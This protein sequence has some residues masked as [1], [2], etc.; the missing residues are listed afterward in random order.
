M[1]IAFVLP[2]LIIYAALFIFPSV[3]AFYISLFDWNGF[4]SNMKFVG[5]GNFKELLGDSSFWGIAVWNSIRITFLGGFMIFFLAFLLSGILTLPRL[6]GK[7]IFRAMIFFPTIVNPIAIAI[8]WNFIYNQ[9]SG[10]LNNFFALV[11][12]E[13]LQRMWMAPDRL[14]YSILVAL[15]WMNT[16]FYCVILLAALDRVPEGHIEAA[17]LEGASEFS[18]FFRIKLPL[19][20]NVL[21]TALTLWAINSIKEF[22]LLYSWGGGIDIPQPGATN[23][24]VK[25]YV[26]A[27][28]KRVTVYRMGYAT[29]MGIIMFLM[30]GIFVVTITCISRKQDQLEY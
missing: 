12:L 22:A 9:K 3:Q 15:V 25:M 20:S 23:M 2:A 21:A 17:R 28:G 27:F 5:L 7:K 14:F 30:V 11:G 13:S 8:F 4:T 6:K 18:I 24:A 19:I 16:G 29:A 1:G 26:T 10:L